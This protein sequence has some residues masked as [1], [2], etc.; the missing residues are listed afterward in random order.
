MNPRYPD[1]HVELI[2]HDGNAYSIMG[3]C[4]HQMRKVY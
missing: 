4:L 3:A 1:I 2:G